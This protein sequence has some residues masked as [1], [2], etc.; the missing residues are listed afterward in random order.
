MY[1]KT[2][3][4]IPKWAAVGLMLLGISW[5]ISCI[6]VPPIWDINDKI[7]RLDSIKPG[8]TTKQEVIEKF[9][10]PEKTLP[11]K[12]SIQF[13]YTGTMSH[14]FFTFIYPDPGLG[15]F[16]GQVNKKAW[17]LIIR[18]DD[19]DVV[20]RVLTVSYARYDEGG[21]PNT[22]DIGKQA[23]VYCP[24]AD[25]GHTDAQL[26]IGD[27]YYHGTFGQKTNRVRAWVWYSL[28]AKGG[29][30]RALAQLARVTAELHPAQL[31]EAKRQLADWKPGQCMENLGKDQ[32]EWF[33][34][35]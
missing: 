17:K 26:Y 27:I 19:N 7:Y 20:Y 1:F 12:T 32:S 4:E 2:R 13:I 3:T 16:T 14:G 28:A 24:N 18:F 35:P 21:V 9:G 8:V 11:W 22:V 6:Y 34:W 31:E 23:G 29:D 15:R 10:P 30:G 5:L 33:D 25:L